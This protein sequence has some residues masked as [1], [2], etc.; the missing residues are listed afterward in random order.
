MFGPKTE[1]QNAR[2]RLRAIRKDHN[3]QP[4]T[5]SPT[6]ERERKSSDNRAAE[7]PTGF[8]LLSPHEI[9]EMNGG[10]AHVWTGSIH[11]ILSGP[12]CIVHRKNHAYLNK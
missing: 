11:F 12:Q 4:E 10:S 5:Q 7:P 8:S 6:A 9:P 3:P 1:I 2:R